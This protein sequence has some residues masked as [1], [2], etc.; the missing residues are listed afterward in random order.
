MRAVPDAPL[1]VSVSAMVVDGSVVRAVV[2]RVTDVVSAATPTGSGGASPISPMSPVTLWALL[3]GLGLALSAL[4]R[5]RLL[6]TA[7]Q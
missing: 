1:H 3:L 5:C 4:R 6:R 7:R 2:E